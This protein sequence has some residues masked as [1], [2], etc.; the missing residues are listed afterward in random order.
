M[1]KRAGF[2]LVELMAVVA[3][4]GV[5]ASGVMFV[6]H[7]NAAKSR[8]S[9]ARAEAWRERFVILQAA[10]VHLTLYGVLPSSLQELTDRGILKGDG[11]SSFGTPWSLSVSKRGLEVWCPLPD[12][13]VFGQN[14]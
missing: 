10:D 13:G 6:A 1:A 14:D 2:S 11:K 3:I 7:T 12:G 9:A 4:L 8:L 5:L